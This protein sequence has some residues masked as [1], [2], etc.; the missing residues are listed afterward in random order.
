M[1]GG[2][3]MSADYMMHDQDRLVPDLHDSTSLLLFDN[4]C[5]KNN[6]ASFRFHHHLCAAP[7][8]PPRR[9]LRALMIITSL[10][11]VTL[12]L[13]KCHFVISK[14]IKAKTYFSPVRGLATGVEDEGETLFLQDS[15]SEKMCGIPPQT[16]PSS[17]EHKEAASASTSLSLSHATSPT[18]PVEAAPDETEKT[19]RKRKQKTKW[20]EQREPS[21]KRFLRPLLPKKEPYVVM[22]PSNVA[23][24]AAVPRLRGIF[25]PYSRPTVTPD[26]VIIT[27]N[28]A[29]SARRR[30]KTA[31]TTSSER[32]RTKT[33]PTRRG[34]RPLLPKLPGLAPVKSS[35][36]P[37]YYSKES[38]A[39]VP[40]YNTY[41]SIESGQPPTLL[42]I[43]VTRQLVSP[44]A[45]ASEGNQQQPLAYA[46]PSP[47]E[48]ESRDIHMQDDGTTS[49]SYVPVKSEFEDTAAADLSLI[50]ECVVAAVE[51]AEAA[52]IVEKPAEDSA[53][54]PTEVTAVYVSPE[55]FYELAA[56]PGAT[57]LV[58]PEGEENTYA[59]V[60]WITNQDAGESTPVE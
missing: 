20:L 47:S 32:Q 21:K 44:V 14:H 28:P 38:I 43:P 9:E 10:L 55:D 31:Y 16:E 48:T 24:A 15:N 39:A 3:L 52:T 11:V 57:V 7:K 54:L 58:L 51:E 26:E 19:Q 1:T 46:I 12:F 34:F 33:T 41:Y 4:N 59:Q 2:N 5:N 60:I 35:L 13:L 36:Y 22:M 25:L 37:F 42:F 27:T 30:T 8:Q 53:Q 17:L 45:A 50:D 56:K 29:S 18:S 49:S 40:S 23:V 6:E